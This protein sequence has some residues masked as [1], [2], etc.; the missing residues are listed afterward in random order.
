MSSLKWL[1]FFIVCIYGL[2]LSSFNINFLQQTT[3]LYYVNAMNNE[4]GDI[5]FE[6]WGEDNAMRYYVGKSYI[7]EDNLLIN[8]NEIYSINANTNWNYHESVVVN[9]NDNIDILS[10]NSKNFDYINFQD[11]IVSSKLTSNLI[12]SHNGDPAYRNGLIK[13]KNGNYLSSI[14]LKVGLAHNIFMT[15]FEFNTNHIN[16]FHKI[17][18]LKKIIGY[19]NS[20]SCFQTDSTYIQCCFSTAIPSNQFTVGIYDLDLTEY[21]TI[22]FGY[23]LDYTFTKIFH[24]KGEIGAY[25]FFDDR[26]NNVPK[27]FLKT[28][29]DNKIGLLNLF[30]SS[31]YIVLNNNGNFILDY[32][33]F[34]SDAI[35]IDD[36]RFIVIFTIKDSFDLLIC[37]CDFNNG[38]TGIRIRY[39][40]LNLSSLNIKISVNIRAFV[41]KD[42]PGFLFYDSNS[43]YPGYIF[44]NYPKIISDKKVDS[45]TIKIYILENSSSDIFSFVENFDFINIIYTGDIKIKILNYSSPLS[46]GI[47]LKTSSSELSIGDKINLEESITFEPDITGALPGEYFLEFFPY[48]EETEATTEFYGSY[49]GE[50]FEEIGI[51]SKYEFTLN[52]VVQCHEKCQTC[53][54]L[55]SD[56]NYHCIKCNSAFPYNL[57][58]GES[59]NNICN[60]FIFN[61]QNELLC[62]D[63][64]YDGHFIYQKNQD[65]KYCLISCSYNNKELYN[66]EIENICYDDCS[67][68]TNGN[69]YLYLNQCKS[70]C[71]E[72]YIPDENNLCILKEI[73]TENK[74]VES[75]REKSSTILEESKKE[76]ST[77][78]I[79]NDISSN[80]I[81]VGFSSNDYINNNVRDC[82]INVDN[83][84]EEYKRKNEIIVIKQSELCSIIYYCYSSNIDIDTLMITNPNLIYIDFNKCKNTLINEDIIEENSEL[85]II[86]KQYS[87]SS[88]KSVI[89]DFDYEIYIN[90][91]TK[92]NNI[93]ICQ[94][95]KLEMSSPINNEEDLELALS[96]HEQGYDIFNLSSSFYY[97]ICI[98]SYINDSDLTLS[99]RKNDII[100]E[101]K[102]IC[103][104]GCTYNGVNLTTKRIS[105]LCDMDYNEKN[106][107]SKINQIEEVEENFFSY[108]LDMI[109]YKIIICLKLLSNFQNYFYNFGFYIGIG[110]LF[111]ILI[112]FFIYCCFGKKSIKL[113]YLRHEPKINENIITKNVSYFQ[114]KNN[115]I[116]NKRNSKYNLIE[117]KTQ[118]KQIIS[119]LNNKRSKTFMKRRKSKISK[120]NPPI[121]KR[122]IHNNKRSKTSKQ[123][124]KVNINLNNNLFQYENSHENIIKG[125][126]NNNNSKYGIIEAI[127][128]KKEKEK[129]KDIDYNELAYSEAIIKD[130]RNFFLIFFSYFSNKF[131]IVEI[132]FSPKEFSHKSITLSLYLYELLLDLTFNALL[133][134]DDVISQKYYNNGNLL[135]ITSQILSISSNVISCFI[136]FITSYLVNYYPVLEAAAIE[137]NNSKKFLKIFINIYWFINLKIFI[138]YLIVF[139]SGLFCS[140][141]LFI[142]CAIFRKIQKNLYMNYLMGTVWSLIYKV[143]FSLVIAILRKI[144]ISGKFKRLYFISKYIDETF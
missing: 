18:Q 133:F 63:N 66:D 89:N 127:N 7:N 44:F 74:I 103:L 99:I 47:I 113:Q 129:N 58:N 39:Y 17:N 111:I 59:C 11:S 96:L 95:S 71:P 28:L 125:I 65:E 30:S 6:F 68:S 49:T 38:Y 33:L 92:I 114:K 10:I 3:K 107:S 80:N 77:N 94:E 97:D 53:N 13:L 31:Q 137:T 91:G 118:N 25:I 79:I 14:T 130:K 84:I 109:N 119:R 69:I 117:R 73:N 36:S 26:D 100:Q 9:Y 78:E 41:F 46:S 19:M 67:D 21:A 138:F 56:T 40:R 102:S 124:N 143:G 24:I 93:S 142:F 16:G 86:G 72:N 87:I 126:K 108:I 8:G 4:N 45:K 121:N 90:N 104:E 55:G 70:H 35:K 144:A 2:D 52:Y 22:S 34:S 54:Q 115:K 20:T 75:D 60:G 110:I 82:Y 123:A 23:L 1:M 134:S 43:E 132:I 83:L 29:S 48:V 140:Y 37:L 62:I 128:K 98:S 131:E 88:E 135:F 139:I 105:C 76:I 5:Y 50:E 136:I 101:D 57:N 12:N 64:C 141:Y 81:I 122:E 116:D 32:G 106:G 85:L 61:N 112:L 120:S 42:Y 15:I 27:L 51:F